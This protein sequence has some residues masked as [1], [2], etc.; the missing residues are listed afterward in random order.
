M[1]FPCGSAGKE[2]ACN[3]GDL[4]LIPGLGRSPGEGKGY[5]LQ[6]SGLENSMD[7]IVHGVAKSWTRL[8][9][10]HFTSLLHFRCITEYF[11]Y[12]PL[13]LPSVTASLLGQ[14]GCVY[15]YTNMF[16]YFLFFKKATTLNP[17]P[18]KSWHPISLFPHTAKF[19]KITHYTLSS[20][21]PPPFLKLS[22]DVSSEPR[23]L[24]GLFDYDVNSISLSSSAHHGSPPLGTVMIFLLAASLI[25]CK[26]LPRSYTDL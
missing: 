21:P 26:D 23:N 2:S 4:G 6:Y 12:S 7:C 22:S 10:F 25:N 11:N 17:F 19:L 3:S 8:S 16:F 5:P 18:S 20:S 24:L 1:D 13:I 9:D 14:L 15:H